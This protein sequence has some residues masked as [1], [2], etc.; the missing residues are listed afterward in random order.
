M[1]WLHLDPQD[2]RTYAATLEAAELHRRAQ[3]ERSRLDWLQEYEPDVW[4]REITDEARAEAGRRVRA[5][6]SM[7]SAAEV[8]AR[9]AR[10]GNRTPHKLTATRGW[11]PIAIPGRPGEYLTYQEISE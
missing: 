9:Q 3:A 7:T 5:A 2:P 1:D 10:A 8:R 6:R 11:P 4:W